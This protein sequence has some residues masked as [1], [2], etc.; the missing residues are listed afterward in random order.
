MTAQNVSDIV[1]SSIESRYEPTQKL[2][3][4]ARIEL[5]TIGW[6]ILPTLFFVQV[7][8]TRHL[9]SAQLCHT[10]ILTKQIANLNVF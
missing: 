8:A 6:S 2:G 4:I 7:S 1:H 10:H 3:W 5:Q 9:S